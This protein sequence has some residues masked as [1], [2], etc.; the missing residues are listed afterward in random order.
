MRSEQLYD[1]QRVAIFECGDVLARPRF[2]SGKWESGIW[3]AGRQE[4]RWER[5]GENGDSNVSPVKR[6]REGLNSLHPLHG[7]PCWNVRRGF[8]SFMTF[9]FGNPHLDV[10]EPKEPQFAVSARVRRVLRSR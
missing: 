5:I 8:A 2:L 4:L 10:M 6:V 7:L 3:K 9:E 1:L